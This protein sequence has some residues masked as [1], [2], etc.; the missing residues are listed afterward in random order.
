MNNIENYR[1]RFFN[2]ME[3]TI[4][5]VKPLISEQDPPFDVRKI[6][7]SDYMPKS[8]Y[9]GA[10][11]QFQQNN[12]RQISKKTIEDN[13]DLK[14]KRDIELANAKIKKDFESLKIK[15]AQEIPYKEYYTSQNSLFQKWV[16]QKIKNLN[17]TQYAKSNFLNKSINFFKK[18]FDYKSKP[19]IINKIITIS[20]KNGV[21]VSEDKVK[22]EI[23]NLISTYLP[24]ISFKLDF[25]YNEK[26]PNTMMYVYPSLVDGIVYI[27]TFSDY[28]FGEGYKLDNPGIW[29][30]SVLHEI[31][32]LVDGYFNENG[33][34]F[35]SSDN[36]IISSNKKSEY[37]HS[38]SS[39]NSSSS[40]LDFDKIFPDPDSDT[41]IDYRVDKQEQFTRFKVLFDTLSKKGLKINSNL[42]KFIDSFKQ[43]LYDYTI[44]IGYDGCGT[45][46]ENGILILDET[47]ESLNS[48]ESKKDFLPIYVNTYNNASFYWLFSYYTTIDIIKPTRYP[49]K[50]KIKYSIDLNKMYNGWKNEYVMNIP[51]KQSQDIIPDFP[52][53]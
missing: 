8:D 45:K 21:P 47:C 27:C 30:E 48:V 13:P 38:L 12:T 5:D 22:H 40:F 24:S 35:H 11:G 15:Y 9:L 19:E 29:E 25:N 44:M 52:T 39:S 26:N 17:P 36:G 49:E 4:G 32:H 42:N 7:Q 10:G 31:G 20:K 51:D 28:L 16:Q 2:L 6:N 46:I 18:Y 53:A 14:L 43:C 23:D 41:Q 50:N 34:K 1:K 33:I 3:S 37:P